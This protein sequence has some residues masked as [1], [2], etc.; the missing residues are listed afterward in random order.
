MDR[1]ARLP[2]DDRAAMFEETAVRRRLANAGIVEKDFWVCWTLHR[3]HTITGMP[4]LLFKGGTSLSKCFGLIHRF[5]ED[6]DLGIE[7]EDIVRL[8]DS[9]ETR[10][11]VGELL[12]NS[13]TSGKAL[14]RAVEALRPR[15]LEY[16]SDTLFPAI[17]S[18][19]HEALGEEFA[20]HRPDPEAQEPTI[21]FEYP[22]SLSAERYGT[23]DY[24]QSVV[25]LELGARSDHEPVRTVPIRPY[26]AEAYEGEFEQ[27]ECSVVVQGPERTL[28]EKALIIHAAIH[29]GVVKRQ[30][31]RHAY[32]VAMMHRHPETMKA[33]TR[34]LY[35]RVA[36]H[37]SVFGAGA[38]VR[39]APR[40]GIR[41]VPDGEV[42]AALEA[43]YRDMQPMFFTEPA[44]PPFADVLAE[45]ASLEAK[46]RA[47]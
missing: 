47:L 46:L 30:S 22:R 34:D 29:K 20:L 17:E 4:R 11:L 23:G 15:V 43:D 3:L 28:L 41:L 12:P 24:V 18:G 2:A 33:V 44:A 27:P 37:K 19:F 39:D 14:K 32:D 25:R 42:L 5:S 1:V 10:C 16:V 35:E 36:Y 45:L 40:D 7:R 26:A 13:G 8:A 6:I 38:A 21:L 9:D 31:S